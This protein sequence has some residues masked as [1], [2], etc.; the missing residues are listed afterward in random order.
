MFDIAGKKNHTHWLYLFL[1]L[2]SLIIF[3]FFLF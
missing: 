1:T 3:T 2:I